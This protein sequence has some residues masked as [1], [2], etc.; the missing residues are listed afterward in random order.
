MKV[1]YK[2]LSNEKIRFS[3][4]FKGWNIKIV[5]LFRLALLRFGIGVPNLGLIF[6]NIEGQ[7]S[8]LN[9]KRKIIRFI[10]LQTNVKKESMN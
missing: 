8:T 5:G 4:G 3:T 2:S 1:E 6:I 7:W 9:C 10:F